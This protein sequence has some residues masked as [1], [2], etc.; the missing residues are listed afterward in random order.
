M[1][2]K[3]RVLSFLL[4]LVMVLGCF[5]LTAFAETPTDATEAPAVKITEETTTDLDVDSN[6]KPAETELG[7]EEIHSEA[8]ERSAGSI[9][10]VVENHT[11][12]LDSE[13]WYQTPEDQRWTGTK[14]DDYVDGTTAMEAI[15]NAVNNAGL[16]ITGAENNFI[17]EIAGLFNAKGDSTTSMA[18]W[19]GTINDWFSNE[20]FASVPVSAGDE[21]RV[22]YSLDAGQDVGGSWGNSEKTL[23]SLSPSAGTLVPGFSKE[24]TAYTLAL[25]GETA[26]RLTPVA[27]NKNF[28]VRTY[29]GENYDP[30][31]DG[32]RPHDTITVKPGDTIQVVVGDPEWPSMNNGQFGGAENIPAGVYEIS[33]AE[34]AVQETAVVK[35]VLTPDH[36]VVTIRQ[37]DTVIPAQ[38]DGSYSLAVSQTPYDY[39]V[40]ADGYAEKSGQVTVTDG[41][42]QEITVTLS[43]EGAWDGTTAV[44]PKQENGV[45]QISSAAELAWFRD[46]VNQETENGKSSDAKAILTDHIDL[47]NHP[48]VPIGQVNVSGYGTP[49]N[50]Y[51]GDFNGNGK[52]ISGLNVQMDGQKRAGLFGIV[53]KT[54]YGA[55]KGSGCI[56][57]L[58]VEGSVTAE[59]YVG[60]IAGAACTGAVIRNCTSNVTVTASDGYAGG[61][62]GQLKDNSGSAASVLENCVNHGAVTADRTAGGIVGDVSYALAVRN[63]RNEGAVTGTGERIGGIAGS[64]S[65]ANL[66]ACVNKG[67]V[68]SKDSTVG[69]VV[70]FINRG[71]SFCYNTGAVSGKSEKS[72]RGS[73]SGVGGVVGKL[74]YTGASMH[75]C[76]NTGVVTDAENGIGVIGALIGNKSENGIVIENCYYLDTSCAQGM[77]GSKQD[78]ADEMTACPE[79]EL[80]KPAMAARLG[81]TFAVGSTGG[82]PILA[83]EER[84]A[85]FVLAFET[86]PADAEVVLKNGGTTVSAQTAG[87]YLRDAAATYTYA[88]S[89]TGYN[90]VAGEVPAAAQSQL[91]KVSLNGETFPVTFDVTPADAV[92]T[93]KNAAGQVCA[94][95]EKGYSLPQG[96][97]TYTV[98]KF[99]FVSQEGSFEVTNRAVTVPAVKLEAAGKH[100]VTLNISYEGA[101]PAQTTVQVYCGEELVGTASSLNLPNGT[102][103]Y[104]V[105]A[106]GYFN[107]EGQFEVKDQDVSV[108]VQMRSR[109]T[110]D[111]KKTEPQKDTHGIY[112]I[113]CAEELAWFAE[114]INS[115]AIAANSGAILLADII[116]N[117]E[118]SQNNWVSI[119][120]YDH[121]YAGTFDGKGMAVKGLNNPLF[122]YGGTGSLIKNVKTY[123]AVTGSSNRGGVCTASYGSFEGCVNYASVTVTGQRAGGIVGVMYGKDTSIK[124]C[125]NY[126]SISTTFHAPNYGGE[127]ALI[128]GVIG[129]A[130]G[131]VEGCANFGDVKSENKTNG[132]IGGV[133]GEADSAVLNCYNMGN[134]IGCTGTGGVAGIADQRTSKLENCYNAGQIRA[135]NEYP[136]PAVGAVVGD[137]G[138]SDGNVVGTVTNC[139]YLENSYHHDF[140]GTIMN[141]GVGYPEKADASTTRKTEAEMKTPAFALSM[142]SGYHADSD[143]PIN[144]GYPVLKWQGGKTPDSSAD[145]QAVAEDKLALTVTPTTVTENMTLVLASTGANGSS[146][147]WKSSDSAVIT[148]TG[149]VT[150]PKSGEKT[151]TL[152]ATIQKGAASD[153][154]EFQI[155]VRSGSQ[156]AKTELD[157]LQAAAEKITFLK[158]VYGVDT[159]INAVL[160]AELV[161]LL[162]QS[163]QAVKEETLTVSVEHPG[164]NNTPNDADRHI[165]EDGSLTYYFMDPAIST[166]KVAVV[167]DVQLKVESGGQSFIQTVRVNLAWD[168]ERVRQAM[169]PI[170]DALT[171]DAIK[172]SNTDAAKVTS[173]LTLPVVLEQYGWA[174]IS[175]ESD[176]EVVAVQKG[177]GFQ[178]PSVGKLIP[179]QTDTA[180]KLTA[181]V[182]FNKTELGEKDITITKEIPVTVAGA[183]SAVES[184]LNAALEKYTID[185]LK[186]AVTGK[187]IDPANVTGSV[188]L[189][190]PRELGLD[191]KYVAVEV[192]GNTEQVEVNGYRANLFR[193]LPGTEDAQIVLTVRLT[194]KESKKSVTKELPPLTV[195]ALT[196]EEIAKEL[197]LME[198]VKAHYFDGIKNANTD[199]NA[200]T[201]DMH[202]FQ[203][204][205]LGADGQ[206]VWVYNYQNRT[207]TGIVPTD[208]PRTGYDESYNLFKSSK[209]N[210]IRHE[211][212]LVTRPAKT[213]EVTITSCLGSQTF[214]GYAEKYPDYPDFAKLEGQMVSVTVKVLGTDEPAVDQEVLDVIE[215]IDALNDITLESANDIKT[216]RALFEEL[217]PEQQ[218]LVTNI[219][220]LEKAEEELNRLLEEDADKRKAAKVQKQIDAIGTVTLGSKDAIQKARAAYEALTPKQK[221]LVT[222]VE[223]LKAAEAKLDQLVKEEDKQ[224]AEKV[225]QQI[226]AI[227]DVTLQKEAQ[228][229]A[230]RKAYEK[231]TKEQKAY[232]TNL[233]LL[234]K[235]EKRLAELQKPDLEKIYD[236][237]AAFLLNQKIGT[238]SISGEWTM[239]GLARS[240]KEIPKYFRVQYEEALLAFLKENYQPATGRLA[241]GAATENERISLAITALGYDA[242][243]YHGY[244]L[245]KALHDEKYVKGATVNNE[246]FAILALNA[247]EEYADKTLL[248]SYRND[249]VRRQEASG[250]WMLQETDKTPNYDITAMAV[251]ALAPYYSEPDVKASVDRAM[252]WLERTPAPSSTESCAQMICAYTALGREP[253]QTVMDAMLKLAVPGSGFRHDRWTHGV[254]QMSTDQGFYALTAYLRQKNGKTALYNMR[255]VKFAPVEETNADTVKKAM[256]QLRVTRADKKTY[257]EIQQIQS[258]YDK[259]TQA[260]KSTIQDAYQ[261]FREKDKYYHTLLETAVQDAKKTLRRE[262]D[263][264]NR[265][266]FTAEQW[267]Q[268]SNN[269]SNA[270]SALE[271]G[272]YE[273]ELKQIIRDFVDSVETV[274][275]GSYTVTFRLIGDAKHGDSKHTG[276]VTWIP[277]TTYSVSADATVYDVFTKAIADAGLQEKGSEKNYVSTIRAPQVLGGFW[278]G[279]FDNG[280]NSGWMYTVNGKHPDVGLKDCKLHNGDTIVWHYV[281]DYVVEMNAFTW[282]E[283]KDIT[284][285]EYLKSDD[286][287]TANQFRDVHKTDWFYDD[288]QYV[289]S[290]GLF[291]G[292]GNATFEPNHPMTRAMLVTVLYRME[293]EPAVTGYGTFR[294]V[295]ENTWYSDAVMWAA[296]NDIVNGVGNDL[297]AP[298]SNITREQM[299]AILYRYAQ[300]KRYDTSASTVL[301]GYSDYDQ[302]SDYAV[303]PLMWA[304][305]ERL[306]NGRT[307]STLVPA[308]TATRAEVA[309]I[310]HRF[311]EKVVR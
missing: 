86:E 230:A 166:S 263:A 42:P 190:K 103:T 1:A 260:E 70:G 156:T 80:K 168:A 129:Y 133:V 9:H 171:F 150:L 79:E 226:N 47:G 56:H 137:V 62:V 308:G 31:Q 245:L 128:G 269:Y 32:F 277:T 11:A 284:P 52:T 149:V 244:D 82:S 169:K 192:T 6:P 14:I 158:P 191:G 60:G 196:K 249:L 174:T 102:Y 212:L 252:Q 203:E 231:L 18:G 131:N 16:T 176:S 227:G 200:I 117:D 30:T 160:K 195:K 96:K 270:V 238:G 165:A 183:S 286:N 98:E 118:V 72:S 55:G 139:C 153:T 142:G 140:H 228:I 48:W 130:Y 170:A 301:T 253:S 95:G 261:A 189:L 154:K 134:V 74:N 148:D 65:N 78:A 298:N 5:P 107:A 217:T 152:T 8:V 111:G 173:D 236:D 282:L 181:T 46:L 273:E 167:K 84:G 145:Q 53:L 115:G 89:K 291:N 205:Y 306:I 83:F 164:T 307:A 265:S 271:R 242:R 61:I 33:V 279:E 310:L 132:A 68:T 292:T 10:V 76:Y 214:R 259:L 35:F 63:C 113:T 34:A 204:A 290:A 178:S 120:N 104:Q 267:K 251:Q 289:V 136:N 119:G 243:N 218:R 39:T 93:V 280:R 278:L 299:A 159:N 186:D 92:I 114:N 106:S 90:T 257:Y 303:K 77:G 234:E 143:T 138:D 293:G 112:Q 223:T 19:M 239:L 26:L 268:I 194:H 24:V 287:G 85:K 43:M 88:V 304:N 237:A 144:H 71:I 37:G 296:K 202:G 172:G 215:R 193:P 294:D 123:G 281:D 58:T 272:R 157:A 81:G 187:P 276:Y 208:I 146:I 116:I 127:R 220:K 97:Y 209:P 109:T 94:A 105:I 274:K 54:T 175:W 141:G 162:P 15:V 232:V 211:N 188:N 198:Q 91:V 300:Y 28:Q 12:G 13:L 41:A 21:V 246:I 3:K 2:M 199:P 23:K 7:A 177:T 288:V 66:E 99:G 305:A 266:Q 185:K 258:D 108:S 59:Q 221:Q 49:E 163:N 302:I 69:G 256:E 213:T 210:V 295:P 216:A 180:A 254:N 262:Y 44:Q 29:V 122:G 311:A 225:V 207:N 247:R 264:L 309:A 36:A 229:K 219:D 124:N 179:N 27:T 87:V 224:K 222:N 121:Q 20:G 73:E 40:T 184:E 275:K 110:W 206:L 235:A 50:G 283:A 45:Y 241:S 22:M 38:E 4:V 147:T 100:T 25:D 135:T 233:E 125:A 67:T 51:T 240:E 101:A 155:L 126:G 285:E 201:T 197:D 151:V 250:G 255:D 297:F 248:L 64:C 17:T 182:T 57:D 161:K 75:H